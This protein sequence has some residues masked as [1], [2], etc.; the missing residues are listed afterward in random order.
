MKKKSTNDAA[1]K[2]NQTPL[3]ISRKLNFLLSI[4][5]ERIRQKGRIEIQQ[6]AKKGEADER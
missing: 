3:K 6:K 5:K 1:K 4:L 2:N